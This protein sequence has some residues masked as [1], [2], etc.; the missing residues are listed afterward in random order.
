MKK[1]KIT[2]VPTEDKWVKKKP[3]EYTEG[4]NLV[5]KNVDG[6]FALCDV[7]FWPWNKQKKDEDLEI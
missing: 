1:G 6:D 7:I 5:V 2:A 3:Q 4:P